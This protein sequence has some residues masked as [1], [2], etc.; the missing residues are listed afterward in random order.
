MHNR[1]IEPRV[2]LSHWLHNS[3]PVLCLTGPQ[4]RAPL[5]PEFV[6]RFEDLASRTA[7][8]QRFDEF[9]EYYRWRIEP[10][11]N[12]EPDSDHRRLVDWQ[13]RGLVT[14]LLTQA[15]YRAEALEKGLR[16]KLSR[17]DPAKGFSKMRK[18][19]GPRP[20]PVRKPGKAGSYPS[21]PECTSNATG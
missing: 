17:R 14:T 7:L 10:V 19:P 2:L 3:R 13:S 6:G 21:R 16:D 8:D 4:A 18:A 11:L 9:V 5:P 1:D 12:A 20:I 15:F